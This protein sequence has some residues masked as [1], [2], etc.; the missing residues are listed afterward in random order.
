MERDMEQLQ[1]NDAVNYSPPVVEN[2][3]TFFNSLSV[4]SSDILRVA[5][6]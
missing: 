5:V 4:S 3:P 6:W 1:G 2:D